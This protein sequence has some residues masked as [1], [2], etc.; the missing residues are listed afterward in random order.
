MSDGNHH[1]DECVD[2]NFVFELCKRGHV[3]VHSS[4]VTVKDESINLKGLAVPK[5]CEL[6]FVHVVR[7]ERDSQ[8]EVSITFGWPNG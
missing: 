2:R 3:H 8:P 4:Q 5:G 7:G 6:E 1:V